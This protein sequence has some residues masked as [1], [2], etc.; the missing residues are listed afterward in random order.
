[1]QIEVEHAKRAIDISIVELKGELHVFAV[2]VI[3]YEDDGACY[4][5]AFYGPKSRERAKAF[6]ASQRL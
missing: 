1:M 5:T 4:V 3:D 2:E 6:A